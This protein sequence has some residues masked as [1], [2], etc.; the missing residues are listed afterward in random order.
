M[1]DSADQDK[2]Q[3]ALDELEPWAR[4]EII[5]LE[6]QFDARSKLVSLPQKARC[7]VSFFDGLACG[8]VVAA[9][10]LY[11]LYPQFCKPQF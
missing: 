1:S 4:E 8:L 10:S 9:I 7:R 6:R 5:R 11:W 2:T 3:A